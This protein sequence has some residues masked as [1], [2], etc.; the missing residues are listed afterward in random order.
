MHRSIFSVITALLVLMYNTFTGSAQGTIG[1]NYGKI[2]DNLPPPDK[3][4][5]LL[6]S[7]N[8]ARI[9]IF[10]P[11]PDVLQAL[12]GSGLQVILGS[13]NS[14]LPQIGGDPAFAAKWVQTN[15][16]PFASNVPFRCISLG[17]ELIPSELAQTILP[18]MQGLQRALIAANLSI[19]VTTTVH[20]A[21]LSASYPPS[22]GTLSPGAANFLVPI[23]QFLKANNYPL[24]FNAYTYFPYR[25]NQKDIRIDYALN[26]ATEVVVR[27][28]NLGYTN[29]LDASVDAF[30]YALEKG[31]VS[32]LEVIVSETGWPSAGGDAPATINNAQTYNQNMINR[33][34]NNVGTPKSPGKGLE[35]YI[36]ALFD[37]NLKA[38]GTEQHFG[39][40]YPTME[41][42]Y[43][44]QF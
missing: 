19:P 37:E 35:T 30:Y 31:G 4:I 29:L 9:R 17:N 18:A 11:Y 44:I 36:F 6:K 5:A 23:A 40:F 1:V 20:Q 39:L 10:E 13:L 15:V 28:G 41:P 7:K 42:V 14:D 26:N 16:F 34:K 22:A 24:L 38:N 25:D 21:V 3:V 43:P 27:D 33:M 12:P 8:I 32:N 2:A